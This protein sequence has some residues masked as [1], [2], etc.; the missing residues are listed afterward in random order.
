MLD[1]WQDAIINTNASA[2]IFLVRRNVLAVVH[3]VAIAQLVPKTD[4]S[5][6]R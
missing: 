2:K 5:D 6:Q 1:F 3:F 4:E